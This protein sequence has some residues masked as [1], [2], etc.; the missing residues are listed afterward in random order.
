MAA[1]V[2][3]FLLS[4][5]GSCL[6]HVRPIKADEERGESM[7]IFEFAL[8]MNATARLIAALGELATAIRQRRRQ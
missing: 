1:A 4:F 2:R 8:L 3:P 5:I 6:V 7:T